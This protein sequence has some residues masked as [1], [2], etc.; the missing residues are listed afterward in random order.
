MRKWAPG[1]DIRVEKYNFIVTRQAKGMKF[2]ENETEV[3]SPYMVEI[4]RRAQ[5]EHIGTRLQGS[6]WLWRWLISR[7]CESDHGEY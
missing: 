4:W 5:Y 7:L 1:E 6:Y 2:R 3:G